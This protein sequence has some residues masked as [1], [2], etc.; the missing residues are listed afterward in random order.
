MRI[1][2]ERAGFRFRAK[3]KG[4]GQECPP[5]TLNC[6]GTFTVTVAALRSY[7]LVA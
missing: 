3:V 4:G 1:L 6:Y 5:H 7:W 2:I